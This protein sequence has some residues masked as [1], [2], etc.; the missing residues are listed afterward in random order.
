MENMIRFYMSAKKKNIES[1]DEIVK[2]INK[3]KSLY[4]G[5]ANRQSLIRGVIEF[6]LKHDLQYTSG[7]GK[8]VTVTLKK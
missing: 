3:D 6:A 4:E 1:I 8:H 7:Y 2:D 5:K